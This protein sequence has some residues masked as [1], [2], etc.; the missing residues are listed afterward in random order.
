MIINDLR[1]DNWIRIKGKKKGVGDVFTPMKV[2]GV[3]ALERVKVKD[4]NDCTK[5]LEVSISSCDSISLSSVILEG[6]GFHL[7]PWGY[8][9]ENFLITKDFVFQGGNGIEKRLKYVHELQNLYHSITGNELEFPFIQTISESL[10]E[11]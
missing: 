1:I 9:N 11:I 7:M 6:T 4:N 5:I 10:S 3:T 2:F 8:V